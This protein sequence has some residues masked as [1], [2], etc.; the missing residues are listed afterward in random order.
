MSVTIRP[1]VA[2]D[3][4]VLVGL[5]GDM[6]AKLM[7]Y[8]GTY[9][10]DSAVLPE[11]LAIWMKSKMFNLYVAEQEGA[12]AGFLLAGLAKVER[13]LKTD[14]AS[15]VGNYVD[16]YV[17]EEYRC[18]YIAS[19]LLDA[20]DEWFRSCGVGRAEA[21][22]LCGNSASQALFGKHGLTPFY[23]TYHREL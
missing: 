14:G 13:K 19:S 2:G 7:E 22:I 10:V 20:A 8:D 12:L 16:I 9:D 18:G 21:V 3:V 15:I 6:Y 4:P 23:T 17:A 1:A 5:Y 11:L